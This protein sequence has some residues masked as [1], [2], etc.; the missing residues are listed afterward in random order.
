MNR[1]ELLGHDCPLGS[2]P[3]PVVPIGLHNKKIVAV[4][5]NGRGIDFVE[6]DDDAR[7]IIHKD[8]VRESLWGFNPNTERLF[9]MSEDNII[10]Y[11]VD[12][13]TDFF[14]ALLKDQSFSGSNP[15]LRLSL[16]KATKSN[17]DIERELRNCL[18]SLLGGSDEFLE[19]WYSAQR[20]AIHQIK[21]PSNWVDF[22]AN[23][24]KN[25]DRD[26]DS[27][28][29]LKYLIAKFWKS[30][31]A[32]LV[33]VNCTIG[34]DIIDVYCEL[35]S[36]WGKSAIACTPLPQTP[37]RRLLLDWSKNCMLLLERQLVDQCLLIT[38]SQ[39]SKAIKQIA[40]ENRLSIISLNHLQERSRWLDSIGQVIFETSNS[41]L[42]VDAEMNWWSTKVAP[43]HL[44]LFSELTT[45]SDLM[46]FELLKE[47]IE[48]ILYAST[49]PQGTLVTF[50]FTGLFGPY[51]NRVES[52]LNRALFEAYLRYQNSYRE[53]FGSSGTAIRR[54]FVINSRFIDKS[55]ISNIRKVIEWHI[56]R[57]LE[58]G[59]IFLK[60]D[61]IR[62]ATEQR[63]AKTTKEE[64]LMNWLFETNLDIPSLWPHLEN[65][66]YLLQ[67]TKH[68]DID[69]AE[70]NSLSVRARE[71]AAS[72][73]FQKGTV[74]L[75]T[76][77]SEISSLLDD[78]ED[79]T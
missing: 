17:I 18:N 42:G 32:N 16:A 71:L 72:S 38:S 47:Y 75:A 4:Y 39:P 74:K 12:R 6:V 68:A 1:F 26:R 64:N 35:P 33:T 2:Y 78:L 69:P 52:S 61:E 76:K 27:S 63:N 50:D 40:D 14:L 55:T 53:K 51:S 3:A 24:P 65:Q 37:D 28:E 8:Y 70:S 67:S 19:S 73:I 58:V 44:H 5:P 25:I 48:N 62:L 9:G 43:R 56:S 60:D 77:Q 7:Y 20:K 66:T 41:V 79:Q 29:F 34:T 46:Q 59:L 45:R 11:L 21:L 49:N 36:F 31:G 54:N 10:K 23:M 13:E 57:N 22:S 15:F 30:F